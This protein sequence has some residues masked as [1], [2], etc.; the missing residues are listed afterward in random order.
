MT[1]RWLLILSFLLP[2]LSVACQGPSKVEELATPSPTSSAL[3]PEDLGTRVAREEALSQSLDYSG[4]G[5]FDRNRKAVREAARQFAVTEIPKWTLRG[6]ASQPYESNVFWVDVDLENGQQKWVLS[7]V[8]KR[9]FS[10]T[11]ESY[12]RAFPINR[13]LASQLHYAHDVEL[14]RQLNEANDTLQRYEN[15]ERP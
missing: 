13:H 7:L 1:G 11:G 2:S 8:V 10:E 15:G 9:F 14:Q 6:I 5:T 3:P 12:W 4:D